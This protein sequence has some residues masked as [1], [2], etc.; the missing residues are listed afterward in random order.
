MREFLNKHRATFVNLFLA[1][2]LGYGAL[3][4]AYHAWL[5]PNFD[6]VEAVFFGHNLVLVA[7]IL[8]RKRHQAINQNV[9]HQ[10]VALVAFFSGFCFDTRPAAAS[11]LLSRLSV[12]VTVAALVLG[13]ITLF[14]LGRSF[15]I[16]ISMRRIETRGLYA[17][18]RHPM[19]L[20]DILWR[21]GLILGN[22]SAYNVALFAASTA[23]YV[24]RA[25]LEE[26]FLR[27]FPDYAEY[28]RRVKYRFV[29]GVF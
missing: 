4:R 19:Y 13:T 6:F 5:A 7:V 12:G 18:V 17:V 25:V 21:T 8:V 20:T 27:Q 14:N 29:P 2:T 1:A 26:R 24:Y 3:Y 15:G 10:G 28:M 22:L 9:F 23:A 16:L 11:V